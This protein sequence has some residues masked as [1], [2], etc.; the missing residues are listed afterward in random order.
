MVR[1]H[2]G[3]KQEWTAGRPCLIRPEAM[4][5]AEAYAA[6]HYDLITGHLMIDGKNLYKASGIG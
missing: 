3:R 5:A 6:A 2:G 4:T 1:I